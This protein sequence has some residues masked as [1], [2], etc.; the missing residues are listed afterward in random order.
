[1][2]EK[3]FEAE[4]TFNE[5]PNLKVTE[6]KPLKSENFQIKKVDINVLIARAQEVKDKQHKKNILIIIFSLSIL[7]GLGIHLSS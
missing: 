5:T 1:M 2:S 6:D 3:G 4:I 7:L